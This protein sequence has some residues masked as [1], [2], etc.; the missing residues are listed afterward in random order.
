MEDGF[1]ECESG[2][3]AAEDAGADGLIDA[4]RA[5]QETRRDSRSYGAVGARLAETSMSPD[6]PGRDSPALIVSFHRRLLVLPGASCVHL[7]Q[8]P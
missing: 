2:K 1:L 4:R 7:R 8:A 6:R 3:P 5:R